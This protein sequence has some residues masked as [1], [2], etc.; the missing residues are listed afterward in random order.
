K[1]RDILKGHNEGDRYRLITAIRKIGD[2]RPKR[3]S[4]SEKNVQTTSG[5]SPVDNEKSPIPLS[6]STTSLVVG[7]N[8]PTT[9]QNHSILSLTHPIASVYPISAQSRTLKSSSSFPELRNSGPIIKPRTSSIGWDKNLSS[10]LAASQTIDHDAQS[11]AP[12]NTDNGLVNGN[13][14]QPRSKLSSPRSP[15]NKKSIGKDNISNHTRARSDSS[16]SLPFR[17]GKF[18]QK[19]IILQVTDNMKAFYVVD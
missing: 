16:E 13:Q 18:T 6:V 2:A 11:N 5:A 3:H 7:Q 4:L 8:S 15:V 14:Q 1:T 19:N 12:Q 10:N 9:Q 17:E